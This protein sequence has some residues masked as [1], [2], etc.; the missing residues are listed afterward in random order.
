MNCD[1]ERSTLEGIGTYDLLIF[2]ETLE[3][4]NFHPVQTLSKL[5]QMLS[6]N[7]QIIL[8]TPDAVEWGRVTTYYP[9][10]DA[11]PHYTGQVVEWIDGHIWQYTREEVEMVIR[12]AGLEV[13]KF[14]Y[15]RGGSG[16][17]LC[18]LLRNSPSSQ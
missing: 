17:H 13:V 10:L 14:A 5:R 1:I 9:S 4:L 6:L 16:R 7:G 8:T 2:T 15:A 12:A 11:I 18:F 3:H